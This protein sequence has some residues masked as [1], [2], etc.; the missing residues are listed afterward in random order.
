M[1]QPVETKIKT[2]VVK[3][4][5]HGSCISNAEKEVKSAKQK[6]IDTQKSSKA[7]MTKLDKV[8]NEQKTT[9]KKLKEKLVKEASSAKSDI[10]SCREL[11][12]QCQ[13]KV[14][15]ANS[16]VDK[17]NAAAAEAQSKATAAANASATAKANAEIKLKA[18]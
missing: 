2:K 18:C 11:N 1:P 3:D 6:V 7:Q 17:A 16:E 13:S 4:P 9:I 10:N 15:A 14:A 12:K 8:I 5:N